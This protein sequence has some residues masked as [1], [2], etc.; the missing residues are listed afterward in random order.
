MA[1]RERSELWTPRISKFERGEVVNE[2]SLISSSF[3]RYLNNGSRKLFSVIDERVLFLELLFTCL[4]SKISFTPAI[5]LYPFQWIHSRII[6][7]GENDIKVMR[8]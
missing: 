4:S 5:L 3:V 1:I 2:M 6:Y 8:K 7:K